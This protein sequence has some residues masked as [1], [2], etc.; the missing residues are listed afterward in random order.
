MQASEVFE[1]KVP[2][3]TSYPTAPHFHAGIGPDSYRRWLEELP[4][5]K[6]ISLYLHIPFCD[7]LCWFC[8]CHT[9][10]VHNYTPVAEYCDLLL[11]EMVLVADTLGP[12]HKIGHIHWGG[13]SPT[14]L[15]PE[16]VA[17]LDRTT[18]ELFDIRQDAEFAVEVDPRGLEQAS[19]DAL[20]AAGLT[21]ASVGVQD[22][23]AAVQKAVNRLQTAE[24]TRAA[25]AK[26]RAA[27]IQSLNLDLL[28]GLPL[29]TAESW[30]NTLRFALDLDPDRLSVFGY[31]HLP[32]FKKHQAL[33]SAAQL[34]DTAAR[35]RLAE[36]A[37]RILGEHG[38]VAIGL[39]HYAKPCDSMAKALAEGCLSR[40]FQGYTT[41]KAPALIGL[42]ASAIGSL[43]QGYVQNLP[44]VPLYRASLLRGRL[45]V[46][47]GAAL[48][49][50]DRLRR[51]II[52][53]LM[54]DLSADLD[55]I[56]AAHG[57]SLDQLRDSISRLGELADRG[58]VSI[59]E[60][61]ITIPAQ[62]RSA[63]RLVCAAFDCY[64]AAG[65]KEDRP[66][67]SMAV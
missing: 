18:R 67:H 64:L 37:G 56:C 40:N 20:A 29:Q 23:D 45:P 47:R 27:G 25:I 42:G 49:A 9:S 12:R 36:M 28:Y 34:P 24:E 6:T 41:D 62:W 63:T 53:R 32:S 31:A 11:R 14:M 38:Y 52:E 22:C 57:A 4:C 50:Q 66:T 44:S 43:P 5:E 3:Y 59:E 2:R 8:G 16:D 46:A 15:R 65:A 58:M 7:T 17:R 61:R 55:A 33:I 1:A 19:V 51:Q 60:S 13:G 35:F 39:D 30:E 21:R 54:C 10:V 26:L 48:S